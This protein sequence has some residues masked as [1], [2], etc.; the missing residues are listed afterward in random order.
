MN[1]TENFIMECYLADY[2]G[3]KTSQEIADDL[4]DNWTFTQNQIS[5]CMKSNGYKLRSE[6]GRLTWYK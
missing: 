5:L 4:R 3:G 1:E 2:Q 6:D